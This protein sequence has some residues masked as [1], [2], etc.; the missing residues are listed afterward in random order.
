MCTSFGDTAASSSSTASDNVKKLQQQLNR[1][2]QAGGA[3]LNLLVAP[4]PLQLTG[5]LD[6]DTAQ[7]AVWIMA[8]RAGAADLQWHDQDSQKLITEAQNAWGDP[9]AFVNK[10]LSRVTQVVQVFADKSGIPAAK[11][12]ILPGMT[13]TL[14]VGGLVA[15]ALLFMRGRK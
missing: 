15:G 5:V 7:R 11:G 14:I 1:Y 12:G 6:R 10:N 3:P 9:I 4:Q 8:Y 2:T 13:P